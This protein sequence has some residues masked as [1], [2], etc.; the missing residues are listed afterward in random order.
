MT[1]SYEDGLLAD[2]LV[3]RFFRYLAVTSQSDARA[4]TVPSTPGQWDMVRLLETELKQFGLTEVHLD[5]N[6]VLTARLPGTV[7]GAPRIGFCAHV[8]TVD[9]GLSP[10]I[11]P[12][13]V[14][15]SPAR[16]CA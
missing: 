4:T 14:L 5:D 13:R 3:A 9:V 6:A 16:I 15:L 11:H 2:R 10:D 12:S 8:D 1:L 7:A